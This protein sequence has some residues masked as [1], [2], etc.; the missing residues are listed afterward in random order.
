MIKHFIEQRSEAWYQIKTGKISGTKF[1]DLMAGENT[2]TYK[3]LVLTISSQI[4]TGEINEESYTNA[5]M[6]RGI[7]MEDYAA[8][9]YE[10][11][12]EEKLEEIGFIEPEEDDEFYGVV[13]V[14]PDRLISEKKGLVE[15]KC[16]LAKTH[17]SYIKRNELPAVYKHQVQG[18]LFVSKY[19]YC[20]FVSYFPNM[21]LFV[22]RVYPDKN[23]HEE[24]CERLRKFITEVKREIEIYQNYDYV[25]STN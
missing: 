23:L 11:D 16:P 15:I 22:Y 24:Y 18:Q 7:E 6:E 12:M 10:T 14:S 1:S 8:G 5:I 9:A 19:E 20:D 3:D 25:T 17:L 21:K 2:K 4:I 13:G